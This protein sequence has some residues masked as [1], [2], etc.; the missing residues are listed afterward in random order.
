MPLNISESFFVSEEVNRGPDTLVIYQES[1]S[2]ITIISIF[3]GKKLELEIDSSNKYLPTCLC[4]A[5]TTKI[6]L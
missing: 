6:F 2:K 5:K 1:Y 3:T 4:L